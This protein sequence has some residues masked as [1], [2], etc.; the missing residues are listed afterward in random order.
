MPM[1]MHPDK[2]FGACADAFFV[3]SEAIELKSPLVH[4]P[5]MYLLRHSIELY[6]KSLVILLSVYFND[7]DANIVISNHSSE[8]S[9]KKIFDEFYSIYINHYDDLKKDTNA[10]WDIPETL[11]DDILKIEDIDKNSTYYRYPV[12]R[13]AASAPEKDHSVKIS[14]ESEN[15]LTQDIKKGDMIYINKYNKEAIYKFGKEYD[16]DLV[17]VFRNVCKALCGLHCMT[18]E[19]LF[20]GL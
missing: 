6:L 19:N 18:R 17:A 15:K 10:N 8:H 14:E 2:G 12:N 13:R 1:E 5:K 9:I 4:M 3:A 20:C 16:F 11:A 7:V